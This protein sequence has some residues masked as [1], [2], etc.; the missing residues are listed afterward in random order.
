LFSASRYGGVLQNRGAVAVLRRAD[1]SVQDDRND[2]DPGDLGFDSSS[3]TASPTPLKRMK[4]QIVEHDVNPLK[5]AADQQ[6]VAAAT[7]CQVR[8][9][10][11][12]QSREQENDMEQHALALICVERSALWSR[13]YALDTGRTGLLERNAFC[14]LLSE[15]CGELSWSAILSR[16][17]PW[18][19]AQE[20]AYGE[21]LSTPSVRWFHHGAAAV[22]TMAR[23]SAQAELRLSG[24][25]ALFDSTSGLVTPELA[26]EALGQLLPS[27]RERERHQLATA[28][29]GEENSKLSDVLHQLALFADPPDLTEPWMEPALRRLSTLVEKHHGPPPLHSALIRFFRAVAVDGSDLIQPEEFVKGFQNLGAYHCSGDHE[30]PLLHTGRLYKLFEV[31]DGNGSGTVSF[32]ELLLAMDN[33]ADRPELPELPALEGALPALLLVHKAALLRMCRDMDPADAGRI[34]VSNFM[35][36][37]TALG[38]V[39]GRPFAHC[40]RSAIEEELEGSEDLAYSELLGGF[41]VHAEGGPF[42]RSGANS[43]IE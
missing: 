39:L 24:L 14:D 41:Q 29:F 16:A 40:E 30:V 22:V 10:V 36:L 33:R 35:G 2:L 38:D 19:G 26:R 20:V 4:M 12:Q 3:S 6:S 8:R 23:A 7:A 11:E 1:G 25:V 27:L 13:C 18:M 42:K 5:G 21:F 17:A 43:R 31:I 32:L 9:V 28:L 34:S 15:V 37:V